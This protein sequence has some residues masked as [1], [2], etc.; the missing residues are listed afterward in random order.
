MSTFKKAQI[1]LLSTKESNIILNNKNQLAWLNVPLIYTERI[2]SVFPH[3]I[4]IVN[5]DEIKPNDWCYDTL[6][7]NIFKAGPHIQKM[8]ENI[9][10]LSKKIIATTDKSLTY[11]DKTPI[12]ENINGLHKQLPTVSD[13]FIYYYIEKYNNQKPITNVLVE[14]QTMNKGYDSIEDEPYQEIDILKIYS[15]NTI[16]IKNLKDS[17]NREE[18]EGLLFK[19]AEE[20]ALTSTKSEIDDFNQ[21]IKNNL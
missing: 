19:Y 11:H 14:Y 17:W 15:N 5:D 12:G 6:A 13:A 1:K 9:K 3:H 7:L 8:T 10:Q 18:V 4:Y 20:N 16:F 2:T 21:W